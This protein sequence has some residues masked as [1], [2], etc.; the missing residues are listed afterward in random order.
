[1]V[2]ISII[3]DV[4]PSKIRMPRISEE[5][6]GAVDSEGT[7]LAERYTGGRENFSMV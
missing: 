7:A 3:K 2:V 1:M 5:L 6:R 4:T